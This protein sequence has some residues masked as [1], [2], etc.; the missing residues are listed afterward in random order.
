MNNLVRCRN[1]NTPL[2]QENGDEIDIKNEAH[3]SVIVTGWQEI[4]C[5]K[6]HFIKYRRENV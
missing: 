3:L 6:C 5:P 2:Y 4:T 1:C